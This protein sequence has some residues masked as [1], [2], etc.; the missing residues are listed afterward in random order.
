[1]QNRKCI[2]AVFC[3]RKSLVLLHQLPCKAIPS[4]TVSERGYLTTLPPRQESPLC[5]P[6]VVS[7]R[8]SCTLMC[9]PRQ[10]RAQSFCTSQ[11]SGSS[12]G[13]VVM[14]G[15]MVK[16]SSRYRMERAYRSPVVMKNASVVVLSCTHP[17]HNVTHN[18][19]RHTTCIRQ[20]SRRR[21]RNG[22]ACHL[23][24]P[25]SVVPKCRYTG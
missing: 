9:I 25:P 18:S 4:T 12:A 15:K 7:T 1:M 2:H 8:L 10:Y 14:K 22:V 3:V 13:S 17:W 19:N 20:E 6:K 11:E 24:R 5:T 16:A 23:V 21:R